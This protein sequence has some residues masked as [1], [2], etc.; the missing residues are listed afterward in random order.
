MYIHHTHAD[1]QA[2]AQNTKP[3][4]LYPY[5]YML[6]VSSIANFLN[7]DLAKATIVKF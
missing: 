1:T 5:M 6:T 4:R 7:P 3:T 2:Y